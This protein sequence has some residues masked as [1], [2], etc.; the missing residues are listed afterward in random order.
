LNK[1][2]QKVGK[3]QHL[4]EALEPVRADHEDLRTVPNA[5]EN[6]YTLVAVPDELEGLFLCSKRSETNEYV[7]G[8]ETTSAKNYG[9]YYATLFMFRTPGEHS[10]ALTLLW[11]KENGQWKII[12][13]E[14][15]TP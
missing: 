12:S 1:V 2:A 14:V 6:A 4:R 10:A 8:D 3:V 7:P 11:G 15:A 13:Y 9:H 5:G